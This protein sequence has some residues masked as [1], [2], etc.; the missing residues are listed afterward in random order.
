VARVLDTR[1]SRLLLVVLVFAHLVVISQQLETGGGSTLLEHAVFVALSPAQRLAAGGVGGIRA[2]WSGYVDLRSVRDE[3][4]VLRERLREVETLLQARQHEAGEAAHLREVLTLRER[5]PFETIVAEVVTRDG[6]PWFRTLILDKGR[7]EGIRLNAAVISP[8][9]VVGRV[10]ELAPHAAKAQMLLDRNS[11]AGV[12]T[13]RRRVTGV[14]MGQV[15][16]PEAG[17]GDL[18]MKYVSALADVAVEDVVVTS[19]FD[20]I[21]PRGLVVGRIHSVGAPSGL[22]REVYVTPSARFD[23][24]EQVLVLKGPADEAK[25]DAAVQ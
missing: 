21:F 1:K 8:S 10:V 15:T 24:L 12:V 4:R 5:L 25:M 18:V 23:Q 17:Q 6:V 11:A 22:F 19:G 16:S 2:A 14:V 13:E 20:R 3:N 7:E 9:G